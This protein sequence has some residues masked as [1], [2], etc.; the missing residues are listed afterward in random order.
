MKASIC[1]FYGYQNYGDSLML[2]H[3]KD[4]FFKKNI[5]PSV[6]SDRISLESQ[7]YRS[8]T[9]LDS[10]IIALGG[11]GIITPNFWFFKQGIDK[12][13]ENQ[14][15]ILLNVG[16]TTE[17]IPVFESVGDRLDLI[18]V[19]DRFS[20]ELALKYY[21]DKVI[22]APD[23]SYLDYHGQTP[24]QKVVSVCLNYYIFKNFFSQ[25]RREKIFA[26][27][28]II[29]L[30]SFLDWLAG[31]GY[32][33][34]LIPCQTDKEVNDN[35]VNAVLNGFLVS[36]ANWIFDNANVESVINSSELLVSSRYHTSLFALK[37]GIPFIDITH[38]SK[39]L[40]FLK[41][42]ELT[43][44]SINYWQL[45]LNALKEKYKKVMNCELLTNISKQ[46]GVY[47]NEGWNR[48][49]FA[50]DKLLT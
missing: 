5:L 41:D 20:E 17:S 10:D 36:Q 47:C 15:F 21:P 2:K 50:L 25:N 11:G 22:Y 26:E 12:K 49:S 44:F 13:L 32:Q 40:N 24:R 48:V 31:L 46:Y 23:I 19:R 27:K 37:A 42:V 29:E 9:L 1:G 7:D 4:L 30:A 28:A 38:H 8:L 43:E 6:F 33:I 3:L 39:N 16:L 34:N 35:T 14:R 18:V 45:E